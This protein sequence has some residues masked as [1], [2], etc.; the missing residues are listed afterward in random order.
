LRKSLDREHG[1]FSEGW[2]S[3]LLP[4]LRR[5]NTEIPVWNRCA[6]CGNIRFV[7]FLRL[8][9]RIRELCSKVAAARETEPA[10]ALRPV[11]SELKSALRQHTEQFR[12]LAAP[13][14][15]R[16]ENVQQLEGRCRRSTYPDGRVYWSF[17]W[18]CPAPAAIPSSVPNC[19]ICKGPVQGE[20][21]KA[22]ENSKPVHE[23]CYIQR[24]VSRQ[25]NAAGPQHAE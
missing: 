12:K 23:S 7:P 20:T 4:F 9:D 22:D 13:K 8:D 17:T 24:L 16:T 21:G 14:L 6:G 3:R 25:Q 1:T 10:S 15:P 2:N 5:L 19:S 11:L 18:S